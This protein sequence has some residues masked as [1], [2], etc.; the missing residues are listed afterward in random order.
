VI[1]AAT[2][3][4]C[5]LVLVVLI[6]FCG[7]G[8]DRPSLDEIEA[9]PETVTYQTDDGVR[10][11]ASWWLPPGEKNPPVVIL[12][13]EQDGSRAQWKDLIPILVDEGYA[14]LAPDLR[15]HGESTT[16]VRAGQEEPS[17]F[18]REEALRDVLAALTWLQ[19]RNDIDLN[20]VGVIGAGVGADLGYTSTGVFAP[21]RAAIAL[22]PHPYTP[23]DP[24]YTIIPDFT[25][26][27]VFIMA[28]GRRQWE[29][30]VTLGIR[31]NFPKGRRY[32]ETPDL[33]GVALLANDEM[34]KDTLEFFEQRVR[35]APATTNPTPTA[36]N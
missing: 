36:P 7:G 8:L 32:I 26:H 17:T 29:E 31:I 24:L 28:G 18:V 19:G 2:T 1:A 27:D 4:V 5:A 10:V 12:L 35:S 33:E 11:V 13:H 15:G 23:E 16:I 34:I 25:A 22:T 21:V 3:Y 14:V 6:P 20:R 9:S 30:A